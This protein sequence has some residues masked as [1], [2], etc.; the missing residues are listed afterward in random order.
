MNSLTAEQLQRNSDSRG[1]WERYRSHRERVTHLVLREASRLRRRELCVLGAGN[2]NDLDLAAILD[3]GWRVHLVDL[4][5]TALQA[6][7]EQ[8]G[9]LGDWRI[10]RHG[11]VDLT[12]TWDELAALEPST[13]AER[14]HD[15]AQRLETA[16]PTYELPTGGLVLSLG[17]LSQ[18]VEVASLTIGTQ[19][20]G[21]LEL[22]QALRLQHL[23]LA[24][25]LVE[26]GGTMIATSEIVS[27]D[28]APQIAVAGVDELPSVLSKLLL[29]GNFFSGLHPSLIGQT[30]RIDPL[31]GPQI[32]DLRVEGPWL[33]HFT[34]RTY[35]VCAFI[36][37]K[38][39]RSHSSE[40]R[41]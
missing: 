26:P 40:Q 39:N 13:T 30:L 14:V 21:Y 34:V 4:D 29:E 10:A 37:H 15:L 41:S 9:L 22:V 35:A 17:L 25:D 19:H 38:L 28:T 6:G 23:R 11:G 3:A 8:Q 2:C 32:T 33:W 24:N 5:A 36:G 20:A 7:V 31:I 1:S 18:L 12:G 16:R 27:S